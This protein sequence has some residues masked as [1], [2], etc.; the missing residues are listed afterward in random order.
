MKSILVSN[1]YCL[2]TAIPFNRATNNLPVT[3]FTQSSI[4]FAFSVLKSVPFLL[5]NILAIL[6]NA[7]SITELGVSPF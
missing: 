7:L 1:N 5:D 2:D 4:N 3:G 6:L